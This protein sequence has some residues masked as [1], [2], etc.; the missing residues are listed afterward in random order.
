MGAAELIEASRKEFSG[1]GEGLNH[2]LKY[3]S[4]LRKQKKGV[5]KTACLAEGPA[6]AKALKW[7]RK[8]IFQKN[9]VKAT[10]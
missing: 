7:E 5:V 10:C 6:C 9:S 4:E 8:N 1:G 3:E 2:S